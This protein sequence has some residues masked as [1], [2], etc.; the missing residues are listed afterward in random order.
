[1]EVRRMKKTYSS[2]SKIQK[3]VRP[4]RQLKKE[5]KL[6]D[7]E[8]GK[9]YERIEKL[10]KLGINTATLDMNEK[11]MDEYEEDIDKLKASIL[12][13]NDKKVPPELEQRIIAK[14]NRKDNRIQIR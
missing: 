13:M 6:S 4:H 3:P 9:R 14:N 12:I 8:I 5:D 10:K 7:A 11:N 1:M 2:S